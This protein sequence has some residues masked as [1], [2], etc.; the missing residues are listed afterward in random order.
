MN[1]IPKI[2]NTYA[3]W[4]KEIKDKVRLVQIK[5]AVQVNVEMLNFYWELGSEIVE[6][7]TATSWGDGFLTQLSKDLAAEFPEMR[8]FS[9]RN[10]ELMRK[11]YLFWRDDESI[12]KQLATQI[13]WW[14]N[15]VIVTKIKDHASILENLKKVKLV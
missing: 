15:L 8:G 9:K 13:P 4:L 10:L 5:A 12:A 3:A 11:W 6:K 2:D 14:H 7:Q 1:K